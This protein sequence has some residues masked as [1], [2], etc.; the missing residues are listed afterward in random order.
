MPNYNVLSP[1]QVSGRFVPCP[2]LDQS[3]FPWSRTLGEKLSFSNVFVFLCDKIRV[4]K[5]LFTP[6]FKYPNIY[7][8]RVFHYVVVTI[9]YGINIFLVIQLQLYDDYIT[10]HY[11]SLFLDE[12]SRINLL[13]YFIE[14]MIALFSRV[15]CKRNGDIHFHGESSP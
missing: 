11:E 5:C 7:L 10:K 15:D 8:M 4:I 14:S 6:F 12:Q 1:P 2:R 9:Y 13:F 3:L